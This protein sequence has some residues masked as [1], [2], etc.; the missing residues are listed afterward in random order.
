MKKI[1]FATIAAC[2]ALL[3]ATPSRVSACVCSFDS[4]FD[5]GGPANTPNGPG[6]LV[7]TEYSFISQSQNWSGTSAAPAADNHHK[8]NQTN[9]I[10]PGFQYFFNDQW[11]FSAT[12]PFGNRVHI[13]EHSHSSH[14]DMDHGSMSMGHSM[15]KSERKA[16]KW[17]GLGDMRVN[18][19]YT[20]FSPDMSTGINLGLQIPTGDWRQPGVGRNMQLGTGSL[21][22]LAGFYH[23]GSILGRSDWNWFLSGQLDAPVATQAGYR[24]GL[25]V[26]ASTGFYYTGLEFGKLKFRPI[27]QVVF[28]NQ[29]SD[30]GPAADSANSGFQQLILSPGLEINYHPFRVY[31][32][33]GLPVLT[34]VVGNQLIA[35]CTVQ[36]VVSCAF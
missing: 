13:H 32:N 10:I 12:L 30:S 36:V 23:H 7:W 9:W 17:W 20:G 2:S 8:L 5:I 1:F 33:V 16:I 34:N 22:I 3:I 26:A 4:G 31:G 14:G 35:P 18:A 11:G 15:T 27:G 24:P 21:D 6:G 28:T 19:Y 29:A 25:L